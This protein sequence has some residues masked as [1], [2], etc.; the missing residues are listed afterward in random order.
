MDL[1]F[2]LGELFKYAIISFFAFYQYKLGKLVIENWL[3]KIVVTDE[4]TNPN[5]YMYLLFR[6]SRI[7]LFFK[8]FG[9]ALWVS[10]FNIGILHFLGYIKNHLFNNYMVFVIMFSM[11]A[12]FGI[13]HAVST[14][15]FNPSENKFEIQNRLHF[16]L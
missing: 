4:P 9:Y 2:I 13:K 12:W 1:D 7:I 3:E 11:V 6:K 8:G 16:Y 15:Q 10:A 5:Y 14:C